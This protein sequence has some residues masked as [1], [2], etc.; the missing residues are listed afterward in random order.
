M[1]GSGIWYS[2]KCKLN[3]SQV[4]EVIRSAGCQLS[5]CACLQGLQAAKPL[6]DSSAPSS[7]EAPK[8]AA[9]A[10]ASSAAAAFLSS[11]GG[12]FASG[13]VILPEPE[14]MQKPSE[15]PKAPAQVTEHTTG[16]IMVL[17]RI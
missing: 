16:S 10:A 7:E 3:L 5:R 13:G 12:R 11:I 6:N 1:G 9:G 2:S 17:Y 15:P 14:G 4:S 8:P